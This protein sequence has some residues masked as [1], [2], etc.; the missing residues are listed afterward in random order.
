[1]A[2]L[3]PYM[4][5]LAIMGVQ[6]AL[7]VPANMQDDPL[8]GI[9]SLV[10][11]AF[12]GGCVLA[13]MGALGGLLGLHA[14]QR[15]SYGMLGKAGFL[16][17]F[18]GHAVLL[19]TPFLFIAAII[20][21][22]LLAASLYGDQ[23]PIYVF[24][25]FIWFGSA[26]TFGLALVVGYLSAAGILLLGIATLRAG[27]LP[28]WLGVTLI[29]VAASLLASGVAIVVGW[30]WDVAVGETLGVVLFVLPVVL[31]LFWLAV[32]YALWSCKGEAAAGS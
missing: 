10:I 25:G 22:V 2:L 18:I 27:V 4:A 20:V 5:V 31:G 21:S 32:G 24:I 3:V 29:A 16:V 11:V 23:E 17:A 30:A 15:P 1:M 19:A 12:L 13:L 8:D 14:A 26:L 6:E 9:V 7:E 28:R